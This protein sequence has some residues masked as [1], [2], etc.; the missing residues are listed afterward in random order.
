MIVF[1]ASYGLDKIGVLPDSIAKKIKPAFEIVDGWFGI[2][3]SN[4][5][6]SD[7]KDEK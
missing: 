2:E 5:T 4:D 3:E 6:V 1:F 7:K